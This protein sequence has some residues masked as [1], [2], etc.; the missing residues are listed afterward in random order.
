[1]NI[2]SKKRAPSQLQIDDGVVT[3]TAMGRATALMAQ[4]RYAPRVTRGLLPRLGLL[5][6]LS[7]V[8]ARE[9]DLAQCDS[10]SASGIKSDGQDVAARRI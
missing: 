9:S 5:E 6:S 4:N 8:C 1:M 7:M 10:S 2:N 3:A